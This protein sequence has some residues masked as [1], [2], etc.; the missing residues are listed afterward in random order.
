MEVITIQHE[1]YQ[2]LIRK[3][4]DL[5]AALLESKN[6]IPPYSKDWQ[7]FQ[8]VMAQLKVSRRTLYNY[9]EAGNIDRLK[10]GKRI[11]VN[12]TQLYAFLGIK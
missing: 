11:L 8:E 6:E 7:E 1:A 5:H 10:I 3:I 12:S 9:L 4:E 2:Q